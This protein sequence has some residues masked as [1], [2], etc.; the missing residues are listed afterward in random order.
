MKIGIEN[1]EIDSA[2]YTEGITDKCSNIHGHTFNLDVEIEGEVGQDKKGMVLDFGLVKEKVKEVLEKWDH[3]F[4]VPEEKVDEINSE[5][6][7]N[8]KIKPI[9]GK[10]ATTE[11][12]AKQIAKDIFQR[13]EMPVSVKLYEG[14]DSYAIYKISEE[15]LDE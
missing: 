6:P 13:I 15:N 3:R 8:L 4:I 1:F 14:K 9:E 10:A 11:N 2:H 7:F 12:M 5:G